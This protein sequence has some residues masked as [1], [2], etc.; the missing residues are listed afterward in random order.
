[1]EKERV[2]IT[3]SKDL[4]EKI[5]ASVDGA[6]IRNRSHAIE[7]ILR[8]AVVPAASTAFI[9]AGEEKIR[10][11]RLSPRRTPKTM[12]SVSR[13]P[14]AEHLIA[15]LKDNGFKRIVIGIGY[16]KEKLR[17]YFGDGSK[18]GI[19]IIYT[20]TNKLGTAGSILRAKEFLEGGRFVVTDGDILTRFDLREM[21]KF[22]EKNNALIT[23]ALKSTA[24][25]S[26]PVVELEGSRIVKFIE[27]PG[28]EA[29]STLFNAGVYIMDPSVFE[30]LKPDSSIKKDL[31]PAI[32]GKSGLYG[33]PFS[34]PWIEVSGPDSVRKAEG[35]W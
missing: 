26:S 20:D 9:L 28:K 13:K 21:L 35:I 30:Y 14:V 22:H 1:M 18:F 11:H 6:G 24:N 4:L 5:D 25:P 32:A 16:K 10:F 3:L 17:D 19:E 23:V 2:T 27:K 31:L 8:K 12:I 15:W 34:G 33:Y 7:S 29:H